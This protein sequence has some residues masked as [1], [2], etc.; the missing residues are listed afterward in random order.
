MPAQIG[1]FDTLKSVAGKVLTYLASITLTG[2]DGK[3]ITVTENTSLD[4]A[5]A[6]SS[7]FNKAGTTTN[8]N[9]SAGNVGEVISSAVA[10]QNAGTSGQYADLTSIVLTAGDWDVKGQ[11]FV[12]ANGATVSVFSISVLPVSGNDGTGLV[13]GDNASLHNIVTGTG[14]TSGALY[15]RVSIAAGATYYLKTNITYSVATPLLWGKI[16]A[17]RAR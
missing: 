7:K 6:M 15:L 12:S 17:R 10:S 13:Y 8:D 11:I 4:E 1:Y 2:T 3:T 5:V 14:Y 16:S 9:A